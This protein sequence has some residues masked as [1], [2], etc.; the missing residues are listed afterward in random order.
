MNRFPDLN[1]PAWLGGA[2]TLAIAAGLAVGLGVLLGFR[3]WAHYLGLGLGLLLLMG[4]VERQWRIRRPPAAPSRSR[5][6]LK[7]IRGGKSDYDLEK[8]DSTDTQRWLM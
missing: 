2:A 4:V 6:R 8:D 1:R 3:S 7:V 5:S